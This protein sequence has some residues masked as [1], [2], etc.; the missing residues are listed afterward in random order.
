MERLMDYSKGST[1]MR[2]GYRSE[3]LLISKP[4]EYTGLV[5]M[6]VFQRSDPRSKEEVNLQFLKMN[7][8]K[9][10]DLLLVRTSVLAEQKL[11]R[12]QVTIS[13]VKGGSYRV[14]SME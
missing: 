10:K 13:T 4:R 12:T 8:I 6:V 5:N 11:T 7:K 3:A 2:A 1:G 14:S 9:R